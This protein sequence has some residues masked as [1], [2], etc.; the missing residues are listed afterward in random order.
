MLIRIDPVPS[1]HNPDRVAKRGSRHLGARAA[2][3][4][5]PNIPRSIFP[6]FLVYSS[7][8]REQIGTSDECEY[9]SNVDLWR[10]QQI[11]EVKTT[12]R[13]HSFVTYAIPDA[14]SGR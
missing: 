9:K 4:W 13:P 7:D 12:N 1:L 6:V 3:D 2:P 5:A 11:E 10:R 14:Y 8:S